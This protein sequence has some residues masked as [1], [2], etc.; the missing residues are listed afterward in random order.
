MAD[1]INTFMKEYPCWLCFEC[2]EK[3]GR[4]ACGASTWH[5]DKCD[6]CGKE[7][8]VTEPRD[9]GHLKDSWEFHRIEPDAQAALPK[10][11]EEERHFLPSELVTDKLFEDEE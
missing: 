4:H 2:G 5:K 1:R 7:A 10:D 3:Y 6:V 8:L 11:E 9:F